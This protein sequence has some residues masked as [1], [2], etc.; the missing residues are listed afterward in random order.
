MKYNLTNIVAACALTAATAFTAQ[1]ADE[2][3]SAYR[4]NRYP[5]LPKEYIELPIGAIHA[6]GW[7]QDQLTRMRDGM[8]GHLD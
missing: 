6:E 3:T 5:L 8:T 4:N 1:A 7:M 2:G